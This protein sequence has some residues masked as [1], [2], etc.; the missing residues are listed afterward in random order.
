MLQLGLLVTSAVSRLVGKTK[1]S[2]KEKHT[3][4]SSKSNVYAYEWRCPLRKKNF[5]VERIYPSSP[6]AAPILFV[7]LV[8]MRALEQ[9]DKKSSLTQFVAYF[10][11]PRRTD[12][13]S[14]TKSVGR[15]HHFSPHSGFE[16]R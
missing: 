11:L 13:F 16:L 4:N 8:T 10:I 14:A 3:R 5:C 9:A 6:V 2:D 15:T 12:L 1:F 7:S